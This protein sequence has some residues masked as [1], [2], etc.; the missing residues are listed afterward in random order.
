MKMQVSEKISQIILVMLVFTLQLISVHFNQQF[1]DQIELLEFGTKT[2][3]AT[4]LSIGAGM[5]SGAGAIF[6]F[7]DRQNGYRKKELLLGVILSGI[8]SCLGII[9]KI[10]FSAFGVLPFSG[11]RPVLSDVYE[12]MIHSQIPSFW[13]GLVIGW[14]VRGK[15]QVKLNP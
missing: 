1:V 11:L 15:G 5:V 14:F 13:T 9:L 2:F 8:I 3:T 12:W 4:L 7:T 6:I 10:L